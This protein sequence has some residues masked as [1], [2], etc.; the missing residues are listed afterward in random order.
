MGGVNQNSQHA[1]L[2]HHSTKENAITC[3]CALFL[4]TVG[5][6]CLRCRNNHLASSRYKLTPAWPDQPGTVLCCAEATLAA[7]CLSAGVKPSL[8]SL[9]ESWLQAET[10][11]VSVLGSKDWDALQACVFHQGLNGFGSEPLCIHKN[12]GTEWRLVNPA[13]PRLVQ[14]YSQVIAIKT[15]M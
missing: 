8:A 6:L 14:D 9:G 2:H 7:C 1:Y 15:T 3:A 5:W 13:R 11:W 4:W 12:T 10:A